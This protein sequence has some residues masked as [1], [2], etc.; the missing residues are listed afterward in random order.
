[1][2]VNYQHNYFVGNSVGFKW[3]SGNDSIILKTLGKKK[4]NHMK[5]NPTTI[6]IQLLRIETI[7]NKIK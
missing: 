7:K 2:T 4:E 5:K 6:F 3:I 1:M